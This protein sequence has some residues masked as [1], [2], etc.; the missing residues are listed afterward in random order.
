MS[1]KLTV[2]LDKDYLMLLLE[3]YDEAIW[4]YDVD[5]LDNNDEQRQLVVL[6]IFL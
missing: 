1:D 6:L 5:E 2:K 3:E 4:H